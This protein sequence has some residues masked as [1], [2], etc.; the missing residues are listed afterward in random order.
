MA[1]CAAHKPDSTPCE[2]IVGASQTYC[3]AHDPAHADERQRNASRA[4][5]ARPNREIVAIKTSLDEL[6]VGVLDGS[7]DPKVGAVANQI[8]NTKLRALALERQIKETDEIA[9]RLD[10]LEKRTDAI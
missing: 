10:D 7:V 1:R 9:A 4:G 5:R 3:Y 6:H 8:T 2:R